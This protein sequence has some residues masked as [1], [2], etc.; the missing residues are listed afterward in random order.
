MRSLGSFAVSIPTSFAQFLTRQQ[1]HLSESASASIAAYR[2][3]PCRTYFA[4]RRHRHA[5]HHLFEPTIASTAEARHPV[6]IHFLPHRLHRFLLLR[7]LLLAIRHHL[8][9]SLRH[10]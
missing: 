7:L 10:H 6:V 9:S 4:L 8:P 2:R 1:P 5:F 3:P